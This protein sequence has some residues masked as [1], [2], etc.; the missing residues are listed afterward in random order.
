MV[1]GRPLPGELARGP[2]R[3][4]GHFTLALEGDAPLGAPSSYRIPAA[5]PPLLVA[6]FEPIQFMHSNEDTAFNLAAC[7][8]GDWLGTLLAPI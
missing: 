3:R 5:R 8:G 6:R 2:E 1:I 7:H 4:R